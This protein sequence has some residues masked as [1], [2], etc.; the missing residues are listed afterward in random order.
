ME[1]D[2]LFLFG[3]GVRLEVVE[4]CEGVEDVVE[5]AFKYRMRSETAS[6][7]H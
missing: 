4:Q 7:A 2:R 5:W 1:W 3:D 6:F